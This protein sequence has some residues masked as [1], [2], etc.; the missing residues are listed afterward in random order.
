MFFKVLALKLAS[1]NAGASL[2]TTNSVASLLVGA[3]RAAAG[4]FELPFIERYKLRSFPLPQEKK[5]SLSEEN[6]RNAKND[7]VDVPKYQ[8]SAKN[9]IKKETAVEIDYDE[10]VDEYAESLLNGTVKTTKNSAESFRD[11]VKLKIMGLCPE[12]YYLDGRKLSGCEI[13]N[14]NISVRH[15]QPMAPGK[16]Y[17]CRNI[18]ISESELL[19]R[20]SP[21]LFRKAMFDQTAKMFQPQKK[22]IIVYD[23]M[24]QNLREDFKS[25]IKY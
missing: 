24:D 25:D 19:L 15:V 7:V 1:D 21:A 9:E 12:L 10:L 17:V 8:A 5:T 13:P 18:I 3:L 20:R 23:I 11:M 2:S 14:S 22:G 4:Q 6:Q 16:H